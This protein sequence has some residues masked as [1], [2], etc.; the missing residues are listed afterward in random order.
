MINSRDR[1]GKIIFFA[2]FLCRELISELPDSA[3]RIY[4]LPPMPWRVLNPLLNCIRLGPLKDSLPTELLRCRRSGQK[5]LDTNEID[6]LNGFSQHCK[7]LSWRQ[8]QIKVHLSFYPNIQ[9]IF[10]LTSIVHLPSKRAAFNRFGG[11]KRKSV[12]IFG[13]L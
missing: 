5:Y 6:V 2:T 7:T 3:A 1:M 8:Q 10:F 12:L 11:L 9:D 4:F 13:L